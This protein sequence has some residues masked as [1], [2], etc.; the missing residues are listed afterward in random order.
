LASGSAKSSKKAIDFIFCRNNVFHDID[1]IDITLELLATAQ[2]KMPSFIKILEDKL[3][4]MAI[5]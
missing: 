2:S 5:P 4:E 3:N 1:N